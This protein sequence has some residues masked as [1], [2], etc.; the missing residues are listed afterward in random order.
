[1]TGRK[2]EIPTEILEAVDRFGPIAN[3]PGEIV[4]EIDPVDSA[5]QQERPQ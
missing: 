1:M 2:D 3:E 5:A 4:K